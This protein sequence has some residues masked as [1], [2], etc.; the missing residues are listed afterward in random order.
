M[1]SGSVAENI[2]LGNP[3]YSLQD[4]EQAAT[5]V[6]ADSFIKKLPNDYNQ[7]VLEEGKAL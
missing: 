7:S 2:S 4:I 5:A 1:F 3:K 6:Q